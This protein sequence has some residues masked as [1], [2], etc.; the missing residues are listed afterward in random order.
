MRSVPGGGEKAVEDF[1]ERYAPDQPPSVA[2]G[3]ETVAETF[4]LDL[5]ESLTFGCL[6]PFLFI[7]VLAG[8]PE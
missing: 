5:C 8:L 7:E 6:R 4:L 1:V 2:Q 3:L